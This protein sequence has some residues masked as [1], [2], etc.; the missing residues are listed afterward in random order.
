MNSLLILAKIH[1]SAI[2][3]LWAQKVTNPQIRG[4]S[5]TP[6]AAGLFP[7]DLLRSCLKLAH[8]KNAVFNFCSP[9]SLGLHRKLYDDLCAFG[10][11]ILDANKTAVIDHDGIDD[12]K[13]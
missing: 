7:P 3:I 9:Q 8:A 13:T 6:D 10:I 1:L 11:I 12:G 5:V 2:Q 4:F